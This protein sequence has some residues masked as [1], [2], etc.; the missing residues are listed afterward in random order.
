MQRKT[1]HLHLE[2][3]INIGSVTNFEL[4]KMKRTCSKKIG[5][6]TLAFLSRFELQ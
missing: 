1:K 4:A 3:G 6:L 2:A 5:N